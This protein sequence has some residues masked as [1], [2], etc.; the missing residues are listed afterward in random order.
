MRS[1]IKR[2]LII[3]TGLVAGMTVSVNSLGNSLG[4]NCKIDPAAS[5]TCQ[6]PSG[7][8]ESKVFGREGSADRRGGD[9]EYELFK[10]YLPTVS[11]YEA[12]Q[13]LLPYTGDV[14]VNAFD[15]EATSRCRRAA[16][17]GDGAAMV[18]FGSMYIDGRGVE[19][20][21]RQAV[22]WF[23]RA[24]EQGYPEA[25]L[26]LGEMYYEGRGLP[27]DYLQAYRWWSLA[28]ANSSCSK[29]EQ[30]NYKR[31]LAEE[32]LTVAQIEQAKRLIRKAK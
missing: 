26:L 24:A 3:L 18:K 2:K 1:D 15:R 6:L 21:Y 8:S 13:R 20:D 19:Q 14:Y 32:K 29:R 30:A 9:S 23:R 17:Q 11:D 28:A 27:R 5:Q 25:Q 16:E 12:A 31:Y 7:K 22:Q 4:M 10:T